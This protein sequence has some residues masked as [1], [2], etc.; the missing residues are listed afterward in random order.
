MRVYLARPHLG[1]CTSYNMAPNGPNCVIKTGT[2]SMLCRYMLM[3]GVNEQRITLLFVQINVILCKVLNCTVIHNN[4]GV[5][6]D[7][8]LVSE[9]LG[10]S[11]K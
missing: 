6:R 7:E 4:E 1:S 11:W 10:E 9:G 5:N 8:E 2:V 3:L